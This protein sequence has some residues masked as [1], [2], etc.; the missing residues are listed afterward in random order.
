M[1]QELEL[2]TRLL[3]AFALGAVLGFERERVDKPAGLRTHILVSLGSCL[4]T[5]LSLTAFPG[6]DPARVAA[7]VVAGIGFIGAGTILQTRERIVGITTAASL[8]VTASI[9]M[10][11]GA[12][13][14]ILAIVTTAIAYLTLSL[15]VLERL[16]RKSGEYSS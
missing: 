6:S 15:R 7:Y 2:A 9:G 8:W 1:V 14:Y 3:L 5:I 13:F 10:A 4:F 12:G 16:A 11:A